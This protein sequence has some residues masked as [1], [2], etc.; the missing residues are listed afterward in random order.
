M[1]TNNGSYQTRGRPENM[2]A[3]FLRVAAVMNAVGCV[4]RLGRELGTDE[5]FASQFVTMATASSGSCGAG[6]SSEDRPLGSHR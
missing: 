2:R 3:L 1:T 6:T 4:A 5:G